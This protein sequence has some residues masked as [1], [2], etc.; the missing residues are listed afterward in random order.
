M[1]QL[2]KYSV[3]RGV[4]TL[5]IQNPP[6]N[7]LGADVRQGIQAG[8]R[9][10]HGDEE[11]G[12][13]VLIGAGRTFPVGADISEFGKPSIGPML[14]ELCNEIEA[15]TKPVI[16]ALHGTA[17][18]GGFEIALAS[19]YRI[20]LAG[21]KFG[22]PEVSLGIL[23]GA[24]GTQRA[25][26]IGGAGVALELMLGGRPMS[27]DAPEA[28]AFFDLVV[29]DDLPEAAQRYAEAAIAEK[30]GPRPTRDKSDGFND[31]QSYHGLIAQRRRAWV[32]RPEQAPLEI[33]KCVEA[34]PLLPFDVGLE[35]EL[36][37]FQTCVVSKQS[38]ALRHAFFAER[39][40][41]K[42]PELKCGKARRVSEVGVVG[43][44]TMGAGIVFSC[45]NAGFVVTL[46]E[47]D[48]SVLKAA[49]ARI[50]SLHNRAIERGRMTQDGYHEQLSRLRIG[51]DYVS[52][53]EVDLVIEAIIEDMEAKKQVFVQLDSVVK[54]G[55]ILA[56]NTSYLDVNEIAKFT[57]SVEDVI[58]LHFISPANVM[59]LVE[60][61][62]GDQTSPDVVASC[63]GFA[64]AL[65]KV[66]VRSGVTN[67]FIGNRMLT[68]YHMACDAM[69]EAG[70][71][72]YQIDAA[73]RDYGMT[74]GP[75]QELDLAGLDIFW[76]SRKRLAKSREAGGR[77]V[78]I[79]DHLCEAGR[80]GKKTG[81]GYYIYTE[82]C[83]QGA[84]DT[85]VLDLIVR[86]RRSKGIT[87]RPFDA[88]EI[89]RRCLAAMVN[90]GA[91]LLNEK[92]ASRPSD[93]DMVMLHGYGFPRWR[94]GPMQTADLQG[95]LKIQRDLQE[96]SLEDLQF[97]APE[98]IFAQLIKNGHSFSV[99]NEV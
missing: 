13:V 90:E 12:A 1:D 37:A 31:L 85:D 87:A 39:R 38:I 92:I 63:V 81:R 26:R 47:R 78:A 49:L 20:A 32:K 4:A 21:S 11:V 83:P 19:H 74:R 36:A 16:A 44:G 96:L 80:F 6:V 77:Y 66:A 9:M 43:G 82:E 89:Q 64:K 58:G 62:V 60:I 3:L 42:F 95:L 34:A 18:G 94:G 67:G 68:A 2:V 25:P 28:A 8:L 99:L 5:L 10:A 84:E 71:T 15:L 70:A 88:T 54:D 33:L 7:A 56:T 48:R 76:A 53:S 27:V 59:R 98:P 55:A 75:Y 65:G 17:L 35:F 91:R 41:A 86:E 24:G 14:P 23:P 50:E 61:V 57:A 52:L 30:L 45:L 72:P 40:A 69:L 51:V 22:L 29:A 93:I 73:M 97:W 79:G 46:V